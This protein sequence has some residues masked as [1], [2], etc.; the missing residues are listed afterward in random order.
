MRIASLV[1]LALIAAAAVGVR[2][3]PTDVARWHVDPL[4]AAPPGGSGWLVAP[5]GGDAPSPRVAAS[6]RE[7]LEQLDRIALSEPRTRRIAG[8][9]E[10]GR[11][12]YKTRSL[13]FGFPD[14][15]TV[16]AVPEGE[17]AR[18]V[19]LGRARFGRSDLGVNRAR[20]TRWLAALQ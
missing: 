2:R 12:T 5:E 7:V 9:P 3:A 11:T 14:F 6:P 13:F 1:L 18:P 8:S 4:K 15:T 19:L 20:I 17:G 16:A 10:T